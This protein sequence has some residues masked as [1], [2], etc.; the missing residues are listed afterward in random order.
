MAGWPGGKDSPR[1][2][3]SLVKKHPQKVKIAID[4]ET[5]DINA[6]RNLKEFEANK[7]MKT[8]DGVREWRNRRVMVTFK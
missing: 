6:G 4:V 7:D 3:E 8:E 2:G 5:D 1:F